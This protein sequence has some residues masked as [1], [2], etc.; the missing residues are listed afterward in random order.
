MLLRGFLSRT[1]RT[2]VFSML[3]CVLI[4]TQVRAEAISP[5]GRRLA[6]ALD[7][8]KVENRWL[9]GDSVDW[10]TGLHDSSARP[11][12]GHCSA[13]VA[14]ACA[15]LGVYILR[16]PE[17]DEWL[18]ANAQCRW[19]E[20]EGQRRGWR[21]VDSGLEAQ[22]LAN[23]GTLVVACFRNPDRDDPGHIAVVRP[24]VKSAARVETEGPDLIQ[25]GGRNYRRTSAKNG[26][27]LHA[28]AW[29]DSRILYYSHGI[30]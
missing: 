8:L 9:P 16:P 13:F 10:R 1:G 15:T 2:A 6:A 27:R 22:R 18:L 11:L 12:T 4:S 29:R 25:A 7:H 14:A 17:H 3:V 5:E 28:Q 30:G 20:E 24:A 21:R 19:L 23:N 26:F